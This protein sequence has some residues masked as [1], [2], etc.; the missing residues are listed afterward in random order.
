MDSTYSEI[1]SSSTWEL[2]DGEGHPSPNAS[3][4]NLRLRRFSGDEAKPMRTQ[5]EANLPTRSSNATIP[6]L[7]TPA[8]IAQ[9]I[10]STTSTQQQQSAAPSL[11]TGGAGAPGKEASERPSS[12]EKSETAEIE[13]RLPRSVINQRKE[14][15]KSSWRFDPSFILRWGLRILVVA[16]LASHLLTLLACSD[17]KIDVNGVRGNPEIE[18]DEDV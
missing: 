7:A 4:T 16:V 9:T 5:S 17:M 12:A 3:P 10:A 18:D 14:A 2:S 11:S 1:D 13:R 15:E 6:S 8:S